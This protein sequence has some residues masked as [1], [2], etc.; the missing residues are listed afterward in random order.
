MT[1]PVKPPS[2][3]AVARAIDLL[4]RHA[5]VHRRN[6]RQMASDSTYEH[7]RAVEARTAAHDLQSVADYLE[8]K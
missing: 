6:A 3:Q 7:G 1:K 8:T 5:H 4:R 2:A